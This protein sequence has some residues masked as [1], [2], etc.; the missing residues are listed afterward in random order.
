MPG[1]YAITISG[2]QAAAALAALHLYL[3]R[4]DEQPPVEM[5]DAEDLRARLRPIVDDHLE[6]RPA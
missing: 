3:G 5:E 2:G 1:E 4:G 6:R